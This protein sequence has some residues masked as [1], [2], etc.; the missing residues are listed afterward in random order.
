MHAFWLLQGGSTVPW[1]G[2]LNVHIRGSISDIDFNHKEATEGIIELPEDDPTIVRRMIQFMYEGEYT[3]QLPVPPTGRVENQYAYAF[4][5]TCRPSK[6]TGNMIDNCN[7]Y[8]VCLHHTCGEQCAF[9]CNNFTCNICIYTP[10]ASQ[11]NG[12]LMHAKL[13]EYGDRYEV[14]GLKKLAQ[15][16]F[17]YW[18]EKFCK[19]EI[20]VQAARYAYQSTPSTDAGLRDI[21]LHTICKN[22]SVFRHP[23]VEQFVRDYDLWEDLF[24]MQLR[25]MSRL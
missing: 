17:Q 20:V 14:E 13:Y 19:H 10:A 4:P 1:R 21:V 9:D 6:S 18:A 24:K 7:D 2:K 23:G 3:P 8:L 11:A 25:L 22:V 16:K 12:L 5:H 15:H